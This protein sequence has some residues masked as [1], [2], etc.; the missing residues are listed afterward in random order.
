VSQRGK[1]KKD[2]FHFSARG[3]TGSR[4]RRALRVPGH[5]GFRARALFSSMA[6]LARDGETEVVFFFFPLSFSFSFSI[7]FSRSR[8]L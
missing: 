7:L 3:R 6:A 1:K 4:A 5:D 2:C 8:S